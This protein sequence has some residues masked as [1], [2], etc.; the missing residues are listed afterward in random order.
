ME[1]PMSMTLKEWL[2]KKMAID[3]V[4]SERIINDVITHQYDSANDALNLNNSVEISGFGV[5]HFNQKKANLHFKKL[6]AIKQA[7]YN[8]LDNPLID[9]KNKALTERKIENIN[10]AIKTLKPKVTDEQINTNS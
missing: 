6:H 7:Y 2:I 8:M 4:I 10:L 5:F 3:L 1:K 9:E